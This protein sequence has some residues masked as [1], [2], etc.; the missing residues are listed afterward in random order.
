MTEFKWGE[1]VTIRWGGGGSI[2]QGGLGPWRT[3][4]YLIYELNS[5]MSFL[6]VKLLYSK[7]FSVKCKYSLLYI[8][9]LKRLAEQILELFSHCILLFRD[10]FRKIKHAGIKYFNK[11]AL[12]GKRK[13]INLNWACQ[14]YLLIRIDLTSTDFSVL[15][16]CPFVKQIQVENPFP[17][18]IWFSYFILAKQ[19]VLNQKIQLNLCSIF[20]I[21]I[22]NG[23][24]LMILDHIKLGC[25]IT[26]MKDLAGIY[27]WSFLPKS[28]IWNETAFLA[29]NLLKLAGMVVNQLKKKTKIFRKIFTNI[30]FLH[31]DYH[32]LL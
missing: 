4:W 12:F 7:L 30:H 15:S 10:N 20:S 21:L 9:V 11:S 26:L 22:F 24:G 28:L 5:R 8:I 13:F 27:S 17:R 29:S 6:K 2:F 19:G 23:L 16:K 25:T 14:K 31:T 1:D 18:I 32:C 3:L